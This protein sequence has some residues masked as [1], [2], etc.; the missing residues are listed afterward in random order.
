MQVSLD[1]AHQRYLKYGSLCFDSNSCYLP[2]VAHTTKIG[3]YIKYLKVVS[4]KTNDSS[5][6][7]VEEDISR[8]LIRSAHSQDLGQGYL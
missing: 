2:K 4:R 1:F 7:I 3:H 8:P 5:L 6:L